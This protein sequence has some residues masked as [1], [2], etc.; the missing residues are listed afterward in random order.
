[1]QVNRALFEDLAHSELLIS[2]F[3]AEIEL[4]SG[5]VSFCRAG[6]PL[7]LL[8]QKGK[9]EWLDTEGLLIGVAEDGAFGEGSV[10]LDCGDSIVLYTDGVPEVW[11]GQGRPFGSEGVSKA[12][13]ET[14]GSAP[15]EAAVRIVAAAREHAG[16]SVLSD[17]VTVLV[18]RFGDESEK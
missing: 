14:L 4:P 1:A 7:P 17:D 18:V 16:G 3:Y 6:H 13:L 11:D 5:R 12:A 10:Q 8:M 15:T 2:C 9:Q